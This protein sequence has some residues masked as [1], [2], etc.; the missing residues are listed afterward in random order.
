LYGLDVEDEHLIQSDW[1][2]IYA[3]TDNL[4]VAHLQAGKSV[5]DASRNFRKAERQHIEESIHLKIDRK[6]A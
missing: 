3:A 2:R 6:V 4:I 1:D 5:I